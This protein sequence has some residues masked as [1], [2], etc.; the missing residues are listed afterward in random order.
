MK[1]GFLHFIIAMILGLNA[2]Q[3]QA[4]NVNNDFSDEPIGKLFDIGGYKLNLNSIGQG[5]P[6]VILISGS[7]AF[8]FDWVMVQKELSRYAQTCSYDRPGL[9]WSDPG[10]LPRSLVQDA[11]ELHRL[12]KSAQ[13][14]PPYILVG[15]SI[16]GMIARTFARKYPDETSGIVLVEATSENGILN[17][18]GK[19][20]RVRL[21]ASNEKKLPAPKKS[22]DTLTKIPSVK[23]IEE[24][25]SMIG[26]PS[27]TFPYNQLPDSIQKIRIWAQSLPKYYIAD[28]YEFW[29]EEFSQMYSDSLSYKIGNKP[30][31]ILYSTKN[32]YPKELGQNRIDSLMKDKIANQK[33][34]LN[35]STNSKLISTSKSGHE[36]HITEPELVVDAIRQVISAV[37]NQSKLK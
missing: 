25:W 8:S 37:E 10:P 11:Y 34:Y 30:I 1:P 7:Q 26:K 36:I 29:P 21:L 6:A 24:L 23:E 14:E 35:L 18:K 32:E 28:N 3:V 5:K 33:R 15:H 16:G 17:V 2:I 22:V 13:I 4:Q 20:E 27:I 12:L 9:A 31:L 19:V